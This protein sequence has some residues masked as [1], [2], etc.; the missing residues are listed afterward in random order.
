MP[1]R[2][3]PPTFDPAEYRRHNP[4]LPE[5]D[6]RA[7]AEHYTAEGR[8]AGRIGSSM[9]RRE[10][11]IDR[12]QSAGCVLE[13]GP[14]C[15]P[16]LTGPDIRYSDI[17]DAD[18]L[19]ARA[20][21]MGIDPSNCPTEI[22]HV[23]MLEGV[24]AGYDAVV[25]SH[26][27]EHQ[28]DLVRHLEAVGR[29]LPVGGRYYLIVPDK[30]YCFDHFMAESTI[31]DV[32]EA[33]QQE[34]RVHSLSRVIE[35]GA[36]TTHN[37]AGRHWL[38][39]HGPA[40][41]KDRALRIRDAL[42]RHDAAHGTYL[43][44]H[45]WYFTPDSFREI[46]TTLAEL[47]LSAFDVTVYDTPCG[48][49]EFCAV[50]ERRRRARRTPS[51]QHGLDMIVFQT[52]D[53]FRYAPMLSVT[54]PCAIEFC[55]RQGFRY[56]SFVG[57]R[58][59]RWPWQATYNRIL[60]FKDL[61]D[62]GHA[63]WALYLDADAW[64]HDLDFDLPAYLADRKDC[65]AILATSGV[66]DAPWDVNAGVMFVNFGHP[67]GRAL[68]EMWSQMFHAISDER[69]DAARAWL[70]HDNDQD[71]LHQILR[72]YPEIAKHVHVESMAVIN[73]RHAS[74]IRQH[75]R[76]QTDDFE[77][78]LTAIAREV[79]AVIAQQRAP[80]SLIQ[81]TSDRWQARLTHLPQFDHALVERPIYTWDDPVLAARI[82]AA[83]Q[84]AAPVDGL[85]AGGMSVQNDPDA[86]FQAALGR[87]DYPTILADIRALG[88]APVAEGILGGAR[89]HRR[90]EDPL[91]ARRLA[92]W[93]FDKLVSLAEAVGAICVENPEN[94]TWGASVRLSP[95]ELFQR[96]EE[97]LSI[98]LTPP[99][100]VGAYLG[101][102]VGRGIVLQLR[103]IDA[104]YA[105]WRLKLLA[106]TIGA[107]RICEIGAGSGLTAFYARRFRLTDYTIIDRP[108]MNAVQ[109]GLL[110]G[111]DSNIVL[112]GE[113][114]R[115]DA[116]RILPISA[117]ATL[118]PGSIDILMNSDSLTDV[119]YHVALDYLRHARRIGIPHF[120]SINHEAHFVA[121]TSDQRHVRNLAI[122]AGWRLTSRHRHWVRNGYVEECFTA[123]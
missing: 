107:A 82:I 52:A 7:A 75:L 116:I 27:I 34:R 122:A 2:A 14:F 35:H 89:Q 50:L 99:T 12:V 113:L 60:L 62:R 117:Y 103:I 118:A 106:D 6:D 20:R 32:L 61:L 63:G 23:G 51:R 109:A 105:A 45:A 101:L 91:F 22:H 123:G 58:R 42:D 81:S 90:A 67:S 17:L 26:S 30:R 98:D 21:T 1:A 29:L 36:L 119:D 70:D 24:D 13:I 57:I 53:P 48:R 108:V 25:S 121:G 15:N 88:R 93:T 76:A 8:A 54:A 28:P 95:S 65:G 79:D 11:L 112:T 39:D 33:W 66:T 92:L 41:P 9:A 72:D 114:D 55:R 102:A 69:L 19:R 49:M 94:G 100:H 96:T 110:G 115:P 84:Q 71:L 44:V 83:W 74:F 111:A 85:R 80:S 38:G 86:S 56:E 5:M 64:I 73:S 40:C 18:Q 120:L 59:G 68:V 78:R 97:A 43:D 31:A 104:I 10:A 4:D 77:A 47:R 37:D 16:L 3:L 87:G 46:M